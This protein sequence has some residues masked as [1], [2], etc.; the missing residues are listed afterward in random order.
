[1]KPIPG[2]DAVEFKGRSHEQGGIMLDPMTEVEGGETMDK[3]TMKKGGVGDYFFS[4]HLKMGGKSFAQ[5]HKD[6]LKNG[7]RQK[8][9]MH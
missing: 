9:L 2:S 4:Q 3:V 1:M 5:R 6:I 7:G 8:I